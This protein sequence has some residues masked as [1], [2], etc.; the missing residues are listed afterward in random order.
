LTDASLLR[1]GTCIP[2]HS[3]GG[4]GYAAGVESPLVR[5]PRDLLHVELDDL[6]GLGVPDQA[7]AALRGLVADL[8]LVPDAALSAQ[9]VGP[10]QIT[11]P[12]LAVLARH[13]GQGLR[14]HNLTLAHDRPRLHRER[15]KLAFVDAQ[16]AVDFGHPGARDEAVLFVVDCTPQVLDLLAARE[17]A[18]LASFVTTATA[19]PRLAHWR[20][21]DL[22]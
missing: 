22:A 5:I 16:A 13:V 9:L 17:S 11:L 1:L 14:D 19:L 10:R 3:C 6:P 21:V 2:K 4:Q 20:T 12:C 7:R 8:P 18:G 15:R